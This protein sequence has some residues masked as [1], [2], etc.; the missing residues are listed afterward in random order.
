M[1]DV[2]GIRWEEDEGVCFPLSPQKENAVVSMKLKVENM[3]LI[4]ENKLP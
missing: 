2:Y 3:K 1:I 4:R